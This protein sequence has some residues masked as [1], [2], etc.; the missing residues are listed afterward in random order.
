M[1]A[2]RASWGAAGLGAVLAAGL[3]P[4]LA[5]SPAT[6]AA[7]HGVA[8]FD[9]LKYGPG[10]QH[11]DYVNPD[12]PKGGTLRLHH[13]ETFDTLNPFTLLGVPAQGTT[14][15]FDSLMEAAGDEPG[16]AYGLVADTVDV[17]A[18]RTFA[19]FGLRAE[20][21]FHDGSA[22]TARDVCFTLDTFKA[23]GNPQL[24]TAYRDVTCTVEAATRVRFDFAGEQ[25]RDLPFQVATMPILSQ[26]DWAGR[27]FTLT[28]MQAPL[29]SGPYR[30]ARVDPG[31]AIVFAR[32]EDYWA[33]DLPVN[34]GRWNFDRIQYDYY[35]DRDVAFQAF[36]SGAY[37]LR[38][39]YT[40]RIW[41]TGYDFPAVA[42][43]RV[44][45]AVLPDGRP[46]GVQALFLNLR[47]ERFQDPRVRHALELAFDFEWLNRSVFH[48]A[49]SR[50]S[51]IFE[52][53]T[54]AA[55]APPGPAELAL[56]EPFR[57]QLPPEV[58]TTAYAANVTDGSGTARDA[59][60]QARALLQ[61]A[62]W[63]IRDGKLV[64]AAGEAFTLELLNWEASFEPVFAP[65]IQNLRRLGIDA[66]IRLVDVV[67]YQERMR[68]F[69]FD[70]LTS[71]F[72]MPLTPGIE[73]RDFWSSASA[74]EV[75]SYNLA[76]IASP[77]IDALVEKVVTAT[78]RPDLVVAATA[79]DRAVMWSR[80]LI[81]QWYKGTY[82]VA[83]W[84]RFGRPETVPQN[85]NGIL[86]TWWVDPTKAATPDPGAAP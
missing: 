24:R 77:A 66:R 29:G 44:Q 50:T 68:N 11:F 19:L 13:V 54:Y 33:R 21:R 16:S 37:D 76:G 65:Y 58:F 4:G 55:K 60:R 14:M 62:G 15:P 35:R 61:E 22:L 31:R 52:N 84:N 57:D 2:R 41:A 40:A 1:G 32:V 9:D 69:D 45:R 25:R 47:R 63:T 71:R 59:M 53:S 80:A 85:T 17:A 82:T 43:G 27:D 12:A 83:W 30:V 39:E 38:E 36:K 26:A 78:S 72:A 23:H 46:S 28:T 20:A 74:A 10:F 67:A 56:L 48:G 64:N 7:A 34:R 8:I 70:A 49:Y 3:G 81:P 86:D 18:D 6:A 42:D 73:Q 79:L 5:P 75:G 51:S